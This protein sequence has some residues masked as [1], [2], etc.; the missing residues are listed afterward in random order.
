MRQLAVILALVAC[1]KG[2]DA[3]PA[4][5]G[6]GSA[7]SGSAF[8][9][10]ALAVNVALPEVP[11]HG[12]EPYSLPPRVSVTPSAVI[13]DG[14]QVAGIAAVVDGLTATSAPA[15]FVV[16]LDKTL[17]YAQL[18]ELFTV[19]KSQGVREFGLLAR[20][21]DGATRMLPFDLPQQVSAPAVTPKRPGA[22]LANQ[23][24]ASVEVADAVVTP[25]SSLSGEIVKTKVSG[26][27]LSAIKRCVTPAGARDATPGGSIAVS[28]TID[29]TGRGG[30]PAVT[31]APKDIAD[32][33]SEPVTSW[34]F[35]AP[36]GGDGE[37]IRVSAKVVLAVEYH[38]AANSGGAP[39]TDMGSAV[40]PAPLPAPVD[41]AELR[42]VVSVTKTDVS[43]WS[44]SGREGTL[45][46]P[47]K[48]IALGATAA[49]DVG[50]ALEEVV[51][52]QWS[53]GGARPP[54]NREIILMADATTPMQTVAE[55]LGA[56]RAS[57]AGTELFPVVLLATG[58]E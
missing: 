5:T 40:P 26:A 6:S 4:S 18:I 27:Y 28:L 12:Y 25:E 46:A 37:R 58:V 36:R 32:C 14:K 38:R 52:R 19:V 56:M 31:G 24:G 43:V 29:E 41:E 9:D 39:P 54:A 8:A 7:A 23:L 34:R 51:K 48:R 57:P 22:D 42:M 11:G 10:A 3:A 17:T 33:I 44:I 55:V 45:H 50:A 35:P 20:G 13:V 30:E 15:R 2:K 21:P 49:R 47:R 53:D 16:A 1:G